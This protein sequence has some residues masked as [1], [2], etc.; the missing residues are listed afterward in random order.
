MPWICQ[1]SPSNCGSPD[2]NKNSTIIKN[3]FRIGSVITYQCA[4]GCRLDGLGKRFCQSNGF[5]QGEAPK[6]VYVDC[7]PLKSIMN[8]KV[9][10]T[11]T[12]FNASA[13]YSCVRDYAL[14]GAE[15]RY[16]LGNGSWSDP[17]PACYFSLCN[18][19]LE[20]DNG[21]V[22]VTNRTING[23]ASYIC[24]FGFVLVGPSKLIC[25]IGGTWSANAPQCKCEFVIAQ[26]YCL[27]T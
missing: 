1:Y 14:V 4:E 11:R 23:V 15:T 2:I 12:D 25:Q 20:I 27:I 18:Q 13:V 19:P 8:G 16:C 21:Q 22:Q 10:Y 7:G 26:Y 6:C 9:S 3:D 24:N 5:W 17:E